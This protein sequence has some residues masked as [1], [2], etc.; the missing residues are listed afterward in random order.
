MTMSIQLVT[1]MGN[2]RQQCVGWH[3]IENVA[4]L[5]VTGDVMD[6]KQ[7]CGIVSP[8][9]FLQVD[10]T[11]EEGGILQKENGERGESGVPHFILAVV[12]FAPTVWQSGK[13]RPHLFDQGCGAKRGE[14]N[15]RKNENDPEI[16]RLL[17]G[18]LTLN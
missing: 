16:L 12:A 14:L 1:D 3:R 18:K 8:M 11:T 10:L 6:T 13:H 9:S 4:N 7:G 15:E 5:V 17:L 2:K